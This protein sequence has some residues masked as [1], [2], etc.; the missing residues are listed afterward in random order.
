[1]CAGVGGRWSAWVRI[2]GKRVWRE[3]EFAAVPPDVGAGSGISP[4]SLRGH[5]PMRARPPKRSEV[6]LFPQVKYLFVCVRGKAGLGGAS[7]V[8]YLLS[9]N[10][11]SL[12]VWTGK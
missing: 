9:R 5:V 1:M 11:K 10:F 8:V 7:V 2:A 6:G 4:P 3:D 12:P